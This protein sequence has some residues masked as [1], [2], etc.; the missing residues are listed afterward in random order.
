MAEG[1][2]LLLSFKFPI[3]HLTLAGREW[4]MFRIKILS[5]RSEFDIISEQWDKQYEPTDN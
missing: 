1:T 3:L 2:D 5:S 4:L